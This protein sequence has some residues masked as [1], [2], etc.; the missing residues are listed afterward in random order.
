MVQM[1]P[2][3]RKPG[4][5]VFDKEMEKSLKTHTTISINLIEA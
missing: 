4:Y 5:A 2:P 1:L 3:A